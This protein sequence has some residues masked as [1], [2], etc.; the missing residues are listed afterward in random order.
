MPHEASQQG[1][2]Q[3]HGIVERAAQD[4]LTGTRTLLVAA[5]LLGS[6]WSFAAPCYM[7]LDNCWPHPASGQAAWGRR[8]RAELVGQLIPFGAAVVLTPSPTKLVPDKPFPTGVSG[9]SWVY[10]C[11]AEVLGAGSSLVGELS[12]AADVDFRIDALGHSKSLSP[13]DTPQVRLPKGETFFSF[14]EAV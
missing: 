5:G 14:G 8:C 4:M 11:P 10:V 7:Q 1:I 3:T 12:Y 9:V 2:P 13:H 6:V